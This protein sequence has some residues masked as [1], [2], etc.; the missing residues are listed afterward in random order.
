MKTMKYIVITLLVA[1]SLSGCKRSP[2]EQIEFEKVRAENVIRV[3]A[4]N[5]KSFDKPVTVAKTKNGQVVTM[6]KTLY[7]CDDCDGRYPDKHYVYMVD[8]TVSENYTYRSGKTAQLRTEVHL[9]DG[10]SSVKSA[11]KEKSTTSTDKVGVTS[12][13]DTENENPVTE[14][15]A[16]DGSIVVNGVTYQL[17]EVVGRMSMENFKKYDLATPIDINGVKYVKLK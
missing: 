9:K 13:L 2:E 17:L 3:D 12:I 15:V 10:Q 8:D 1:L 11:D 4:L 5:Q 7:I 16:D 14:E 6:A